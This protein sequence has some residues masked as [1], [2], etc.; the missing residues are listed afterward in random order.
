MKENSVLSAL[1]EAYNA[2]WKACDLWNENSEG[3]DFNEVDGIVDSY[4]FTKSLD[5]VANDFD[6]WILDI[7]EAIEN[8][9]GNKS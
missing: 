9:K 6:S 7:E 5:E 8:Q 4:P 2:L 1:V 3:I